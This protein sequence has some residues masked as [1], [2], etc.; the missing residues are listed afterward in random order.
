MTLSTVHPAPS[1]MPTGSVPFSGRWAGGVGRPALFPVTSALPARPVATGRDSARPPAGSLRP[2]PTAVPDRV[3]PPRGP[4]V[5]AVR[6]PALGAPAASG[7]AVGAPAVGDGRRPR[8]A[9]VRRPTRTENGPSPLSLV[10]DSPAER[11]SPADTSARVPD[12][13]KPATVPDRASAAGSSSGPVT[14][15]AAPR[16]TSAGQPSAP[17]GRRAARGGTARDGTTRERAARDGAA[18]EAP[19]PQP[20]RDLLADAG[21]GLGRAIGEGAP[22]DRY[23]AAHLAALRAAAAVLAARAR[24]VRGRRGSAWELMTKV[25]PDLAEWAAFFAAGSSK[26]RA[27]EAGV[28]TS[29]SAREADDMIRQVAVF[30]E[31]A[32]RAVHRS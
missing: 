4:E 32:E 9:A 8:G 21:R 12:R 7:Q 6:A 2:R 19:V 31:L 25:A 13:V 30:L 29:I 28:P 27:A 11:S 3:D 16:A 26:R 5:P 15:R 20:V 23:A 22:A 18:G 24:P 1:A 10:P 14:R 17:A